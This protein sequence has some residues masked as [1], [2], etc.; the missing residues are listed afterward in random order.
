MKRFIFGILSVMLAL[1]SFSACQKKSKNANE[2]I[3]IG[4]CSVDTSSQ[5]LA[6]LTNATQAN[7]AKD[8]IKMQIASAQLSSATQI[9]QIENYATMGAKVIIL[10]PADPTSCADAIRRAQRAGTKVLVLNS[11]TGVY[12]S[13]MHSDRLAIGKSSAQLAAKWINETFPN[14]QPGSIEIAL[15]ENRDTPELSEHSDGMQ[16]ITKMTDKVKVVQ[17]F[18]G[19]G[20]NAQGQE[21]AA[22]LFQSYPNVK[23]II[24]TVSEVAIG[25]N[26]YVM[27]QDSKVKN[28][29]EFG[30]FAADYTS[31]IMQHIKDSASDKSAYRGSVKFGGDDLPGDIY[32]LAKKMALG[33]D[34]PKEWVDPY[35]GIDRDNVDQYPQ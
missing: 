2:D 24:C 22:S 4:F 19:L 8:G 29:S 6:D 25:A 15:F 27:R 5:F 3:L 35:I 33:E 13:I 11:D 26:A 21:A 10:L 31:E 14:A 1:M 16:E 12:D 20:T 34:F 30:I 7:F 18:G 23:A 28:I 17:V 32:R 9:A